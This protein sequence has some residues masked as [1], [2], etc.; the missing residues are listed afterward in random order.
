MFCAL[1]KERKKFHVHYLER[2]VDR[3]SAWVLTC[4][5]SQA[6]RCIRLFDF[7]IR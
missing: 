2:G 7:G 3:H 5:C 6:S 1:E 4:G